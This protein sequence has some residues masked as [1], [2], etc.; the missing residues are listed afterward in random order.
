MQKVMV[1]AAFAAASLLAACD[2]KGGKYMEV[3]GGGFL[4]NYR[5]AEATVGLV[6]VPTRELPEGASVEVTFENP[7]GGAPIVMKKDA[8][9]RKMQ[10]DFTTPPLFGIVADKTIL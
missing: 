2:N 4:F 8:S 1:F 6:V 10:L 3:V 7:A 9:K 5:I